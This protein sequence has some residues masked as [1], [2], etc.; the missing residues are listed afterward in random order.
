LVTDVATVANLFPGLCAHHSGRRRQMPWAVASLHPTRI[1]T[2][3]WM[4]VLEKQSNNS[5]ASSPSPSL[6]KNPNTSLVSNRLTSSELQSLKQDAKEA[7]AYLQK[8]FPKS[9]LAK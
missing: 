8:E 2:K 5:L 7:L 9:R 1:W 6:Q 4:H 3:N